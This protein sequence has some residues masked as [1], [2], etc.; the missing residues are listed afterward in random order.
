MRKVDADSHQ[1]DLVAGTGEAGYSGEA[2]LA[3]KSKL[4]EPYG[5]AFDGEGTLFIVDTMNNRIREIVK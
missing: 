5:L 1:I 4:R 2:V 3:T